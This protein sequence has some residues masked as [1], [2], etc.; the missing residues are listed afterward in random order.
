MDGYA[1][2]QE[3]PKDCG[4]GEGNRRPE[5][6]RLHNPVAVASDSHRLLGLKHCYLLRFSW[7]LSN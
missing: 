5:L 1:T 4:N 7:R 2:R 6:Q 3:T